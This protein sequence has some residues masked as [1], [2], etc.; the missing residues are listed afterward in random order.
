MAAHDD[1]RLLSIF[2]Y[3]L[4]GL[5]ALFAF[6]PLLYIG[7]GVLFSSGAMWKNEPIPPPAF[8]GW[9]F[10]GL[11]SFFFLLLV[12][13]VVMLIVAGKSLGRQRRWLYCMIVAGISCASFPF[14][15]ALGVFTLITLS[16]P[17]VKALFTAPRAG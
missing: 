15:T 5:S 6:V 3:V 16:K 1:V 10:I 14:G 9:I 13:W 2:H 7:M 12:G 4:A 8:I 17:D 11:G